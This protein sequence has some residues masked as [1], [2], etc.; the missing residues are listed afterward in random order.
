MNEQFNDIEET[1]EEVKEFLP[2]LIAAAESVSE[3]FYKPVTD[4]TWEAFGEVVQGMDD[5]YRTLQSLCKSRCLYSALQPVL[6]DFITAM[7][8]KFTQMNRYM[9][10]EDYI[11]AADVMN[12][13]L[14]QRFR[15]LAT[16]LG[17]S[18]AVKEQRFAANL[19]FLKAKFPHV[20]QQVN[21]VEVEEHKYQIIY[22]DNGSPNLY[23]PGEGDKAVYFYSQ[24]NPCYEADRWVDSIAHSAMGKS[25][26]LIYGFGFGYHLKSLSDSYERH[27]CYIYEPDVQILLAAMQVIDLEP[28]FTRKNVKDLAVGQDKNEVDQLFYRFMAKIK[29]ETSTVSLPVYDRIAPGQK[30]KF[31]QDAKIAM[32]N[33][34]FSKSIHQKLGIQ[35]T[36][37]R[38]YNMAVNV[39]SPSLLGLKGKLNGV[40]A[41]IV[42]A[43]P[44]L[45]EDI[46]HLRI[47]KEH[48]LIIAAGSSTQSLFHYGIEPHLI[49]S[50]DGDTPNYAAFAHLQ[51]DHIPF[52]YAPQLE[53]RIIENKTFNIMHV[54]FSNDLVTQV[55]MGVTQDD[56]V[57][58][59]NHSVTG[60]AIQAAIFMGC[61]Q[62]VFTGQDLSYPGEIVYAPGA[63][64]VSQETPDQVKSR[65]TELVENIQGGYNRTTEGFKLVQADI[66]ELLSHYPEVHFINCS[67]LGA[68]IEHTVFRPMDE[69]LYEL[70]NHELDSDFFRRAMNEHLRDYDDVR[71]N[72]AIS[73]ILEV[74]VML[75][76]MESKLHRINN[77]LDK[78]PE[79][80]RLKPLK[81]LHAMVSI[82]EDWGSV[83]KSLLFNTLFMA[84][85]ENEIREFD[86]NLP[87]VAD[88]SNVIKKADLFCQVLGPLVDK[89][90][91]TI[92]EFIEMV[93]ET[94]RRI[95][96]RSEIKASEVLL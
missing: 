65:A 57:F 54:F 86:R 87:D 59:S 81:C 30:L 18:K 3:L 82:E 45:K 53:S 12:Y 33:F 67:R 60:T 13:E 31:I 52:L 15:H 26:V 51:T 36:K 8:E 70:K 25:N 85:I 74:P 46:E 48:A 1:L 20:Y 90:L 72:A 10:E 61:Q 16:R 32:L 96:A 6:E 44:S 50:M 49:V 27:H 83:V 93:E 78:L 79:L 95:K 77:Q 40:T 19:N 76:D 35:W 71:K 37:N 64:H 75:R 24:Y 58:A 9:D 73:R 43:G 47:L 66:E 62:I 89:M 94:N 17:D 84:A 34:A 28:I 55:L 63:V 21:D 14:A 23:I 4:Q 92:P 91:E 11:A 56:A 69:V 22:A 80:S 38:L 2:R 7:G 5:L 68:K 41:V 29:G 42:G 88:E 39:H